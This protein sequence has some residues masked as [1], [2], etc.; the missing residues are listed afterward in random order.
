MRAASDHLARTA[1]SLEQIVAG[2]EGAALAVRGLGPRRDLQQLVIDVRDTST[3]VRALARSLRERSV[4]AHP[5]RAARSAWRFR[6]EP[7]RRARCRWR[8]VVQRVPGT[9]RAG[10]KRERPDHVPAARRRALEAAAG[11]RSDAHARRRAPARGARARH[12]TAIAVVRPGQS[13]DYYAGVR[14]AEPAP[15][16]CSRLLVQAL[17]APA[18]FATVVS[19]PSRA[20]RASCCSMSSCGASRPWP[21]TRQ[22]APRVHVQMQVTPGRRTRTA[23]DSR[24]HSLSDAERPPPR[25]RR[26]DVIDAFEQATSAAL[27]EVV[28]RRCVNPRSSATAGDGGA[29][30]LALQSGGLQQIPSRSGRQAQ[31]RVLAGGLADHHVEEFGRGDRRRRTAVPGRTGSRCARRNSRCSSVSMPSA[32]TCRPRLRPI[33][34]IVRTIVASS[35]SVA[36]LRH[37]RLVDLERADRELLQRAQAR[38]A[39]AEIV[40][41]QVHAHRAQLVEQRQRAL[42]IHHQCRLGDLELDA[43]RGTT[44]CCSNTE[45]QRGMKLA[46]LSSLSDRLIAMRPG[47]ATRFCHAA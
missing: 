27:L 5:A 1:A 4:A 21:T 32:T 46:W 20:Y 11:D 17:A 36:A 13:F 35:G 24:A 18:R 43:R 23:R 22:S 12:A 10:S 6:D 8:C 39:R 29:P 38:I 19:A 16:C 47:S 31:D 2:N 9:W 34:M 26:S 44:P 3:E 7:V 42:G 45:R 15:R 37:E 41:R 25:N 33:S 30:S 14:W 40:D 28:A